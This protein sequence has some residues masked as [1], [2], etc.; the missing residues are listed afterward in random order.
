MTVSND[1][2]C[3]ARSALR[4]SVAHV[5][6]MS[7]F[8]LSLRQRLTAGG[9]EHA[10]G[11]RNARR[12]TDAGSSPRSSKGFFSQSQLSVHR[13]SP[14]VFLQP[15]C[16]VACIKLRA[17]VT[18]EIPNAGSYTILSSTCHSNITSVMFSGACPNRTGVPSLFPATD[19]FR[20]WDK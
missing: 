15:P 2:F 20:C 5:Q 18:N 8:H 9:M 6:I 3:T 4:S 1:F 16:A 14:T 10:A 19:N 13:H 17:H 7:H 12:S 11:N